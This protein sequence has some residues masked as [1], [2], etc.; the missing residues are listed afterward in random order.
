MEARRRDTMANT[1]TEEPATKPVVQRFNLALV[2]RFFMDKRRAERLALALPVTYLIEASGG[3]LEGR[4][5]TI[6][7]GSA[8][9]Q[10]TV[11]TMVSPQTACQIDL[12][13]PGHPEPLSFR[14]RVA[15]C[16]VGRRAYEVG[17]AFTR[18]STYT[19]PT[20]ALLS[21]FIADLLLRRH[22]GG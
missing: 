20:F 16:R 10:M 11:P 3:R 21:R 13:L 17:I 2:R 6:D 4:T 18:P 8:G 12:A 22:L 14:G 7:V 19:D 1:A 5:T 15:W 9:V